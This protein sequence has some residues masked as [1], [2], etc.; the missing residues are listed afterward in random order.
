MRRPCGFEMKTV[1]AGAGATHERAQ[2][3]EEGIV[4][5]RRHEYW[6]RSRTCSDTAAVILDPRRGLNLL[7]TKGLFGG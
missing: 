6:G 5:D 7:R 3:S 2:A 1:G 4:A